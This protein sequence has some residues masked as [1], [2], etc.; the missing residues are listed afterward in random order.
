MGANVDQAE[1]ELF[2]ANVRRFL[3][4]HVAPNASAWRERGYI[5][6]DLWRKAGALGLLCASSPE[7]YGGGWRHVL[8]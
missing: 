7:E 3:A 5:D 4:E 6:R 2:R 1:L 8:A